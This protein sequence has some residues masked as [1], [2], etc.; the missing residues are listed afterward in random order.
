M[1]TRFNLRQC[2]PC[3]MAAALSLS[4]STSMS[5][6][7]ALPV[8]P[9]YTTN[10]TQSP[11]NAN[12]NGIF[13]NTTAIQNAINDV[14]GKGGGTVEIPGPGVYLTGPLTMKSKINLQIDS[15]AILRMLPMASWTGA[16]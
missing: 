15:G 6:A 13:T 3:L 12:A 16:S 4:L 11:Y 14:S 1:T 8:I 10:V 7:P 2:V 5:A 9:A